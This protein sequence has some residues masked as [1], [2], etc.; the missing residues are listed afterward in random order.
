MTNRVQTLVLLGLTL[1]YL[2]I[3]VAQR[4]LQQT[5]R[6]RFTYQR[7]KIMKQIT[8]QSLAQ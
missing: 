4:L 1:A 7:A 6:V 8:A 5:K 2:Y 3:Q